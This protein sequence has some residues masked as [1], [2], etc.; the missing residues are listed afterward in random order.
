MQGFSLSFWQGNTVIGR[1]REYR[2]HLRGVCKLA[3]FD[4]KP[5]LARLG[6]THEMQCAQVNDTT[7]SVLPVES[8]TKNAVGDMGQWSSCRYCLTGFEVTEDIRI[9]IADSQGA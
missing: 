4:L 6:V 3:K 7:T 1:F 2:S 9:F 5:T 8:E